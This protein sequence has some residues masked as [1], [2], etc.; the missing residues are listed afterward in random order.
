MTYYSL[1]YFRNNSTLYKLAEK[2]DST[3]QKG[4]NDRVLNGGEIKLFSNEIKSLG[5]EFDFAQ[6]KDSKYLDKFQE[7]F[8]RAQ[9]QEKERNE[10]IKDKKG[11]Y[12]INIVERNG[13]KM[14]AIKVLK[15]INCGSVSSDLN[16][17]GGAIAK[18]NAGY[19]QYDYD[20]H[21]ISNKPMQNQ[22][23]YVDINDLNATSWKNIGR[24]FVDWI[25][26]W[27]SD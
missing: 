4:N 13:K 3:E 9:N 24:G 11:E 21:H 10:L 19:G 6:V 17:P 12:E 2:Y 7:N 22:V 26:N 18:N 16:L 14:Y 1:D 5:L 27:E 23:I 20:G 15:E 8:E 25:T